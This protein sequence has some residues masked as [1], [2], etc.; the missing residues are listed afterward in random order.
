MT[1]VPLISFLLDPFDFK[2]TNRS[3][4]R[5]MKKIS[6]KFIYLS[7]KKNV[8]FIH[9]FMII[10]LNDHKNKYITDVKVIKWF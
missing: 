2:F 9:N 6:Y 5:I 7:G 3:H 4:L 10:F 8:I 1:I